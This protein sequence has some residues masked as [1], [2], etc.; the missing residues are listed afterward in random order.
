MPFET[1]LFLIALAGIVSA[2]ITGIVKAI[3]RR[4]PSA[5]QLAQLKAELEQHRGAL[6]EAHA[7]LAAQATQLA[8]LQERVDF[9]ERLLAQ[10]RD[11]PPLGAPERS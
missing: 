10:T 7:A 5:T 11:R 3:V 2:T 8:E 6:V 9:A 1:G 4:G